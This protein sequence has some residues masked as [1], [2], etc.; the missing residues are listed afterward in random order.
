MTAKLTGRSRRIGAKGAGGTG[1]GPLTSVS[2]SGT[3]SIANGASGTVTMDTTEASA[4][5]AFPD[6]QL[7]RES[8]RVEIFPAAALGQ[9][10][11][12]PWDTLRPP[13][14]HR[15]HG[16]TFLVRQEDVEDWLHAGNRRAAVR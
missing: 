14:R 11:V 3:Q 7:R 6:E 10:N 16:V 15:R 8:Q 1:V 4:N 2:K 13:I 12:F 5:G 9:D